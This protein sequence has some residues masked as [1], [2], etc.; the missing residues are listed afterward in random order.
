MGK[1]EWS[2]FSGSHEVEETVHKPDGRAKV[3]E[4]DRVLLRPEIGQEMGLGFLLVRHE[5]DDLDGQSI[6]IFT[7]DKIGISKEAP[8]VLGG[9]NT[10]R[11]PK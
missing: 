10:Q 11:L 9:L 8:N 4:P 7:G 1:W 2:L 6:A 5:G 3:S